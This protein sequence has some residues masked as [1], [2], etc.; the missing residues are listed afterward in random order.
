MSTYLDVS[1]TLRGKTAILNKPFKLAGV[2]VPAGFESDGIS[3]PR[4]TWFIWHPFSF[5]CPAAFV[6]DFLI[7]S[8]GYEYARD[9]FKVAL[10]ALGLPRWEVFALYNAVR[11]KDYL[12][13]HGIKL[14]G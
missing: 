12:Q 1:F 6:H 10:V 5:A 7:E 14:G 13:R 4:I 11:F 2:T 3:S 9:K 8:K